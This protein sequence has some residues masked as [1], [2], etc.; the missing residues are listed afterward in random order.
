[1]EQEAFQLDVYHPAD[2]W[3]VS[4]VLSGWPGLAQKMWGTIQMVPGSMPTGG[5]FIF[6]LEYSVSLNVNIVQNCQLLYNYRSCI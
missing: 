3:K 4:S 6:L 1:M 2:P 5:N